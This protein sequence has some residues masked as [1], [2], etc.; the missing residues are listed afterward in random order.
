M[1]L[2]LERGRDRLRKGQQLSFC[3]FNFH[4]VR[5][6]TIRNYNIT[7]SKD[8]IHLTRVRTNWGKQRFMYQ[9]VIDWNSLSQ[10]IRDISIFY[11]FKYKLKHAF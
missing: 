6:N 5:N 10:D 7:R 4:F 8:D 9:S 3:Y 11:Y 1:R 2:H